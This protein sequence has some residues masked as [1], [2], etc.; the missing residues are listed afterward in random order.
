MKKLSI[1]LV[2]AL[3]LSLF[4]GCTAPEA[5]GTDSLRV[6]ITSSKTDTTA[7]GSDADTDSS[8]VSSGTHSGGSAS[9][10]IS[11]GTESDNGEPSFADERTELLDPSL[12]ET[13]RT[14]FIAQY[15]KSGNSYEP[16]S[17]FLRVCSVFEDA[18]V[19]FVDAPWQRV[20]NYMLTES[21]AEQHFVYPT[22]NA[23]KVYREGRFYSLEEAYQGNYLTEKQIISVCDAFYWNFEMPLRYNYGE[24]S[25]NQKNPEISMPDA[26]EFCVPQEGLSALRSEEQ[27]AKA[28]ALYA[29]FSQITPLTRGMLHRL[30]NVFYGNNI[31]VRLPHDY[32]G[33]YAG[34]TVL[35]H[36][37][38]KADAITELPIGEFTFRDEGRFEFVAYKEGEF[39]SLEQLYATG[40]VTA[41][42]LN[43]IYELHK[44]RY[45]VF[46]GADNSAYAVPEE[47][48]G[49]LKKHSAEIEEKYPNSGAV[50]DGSHVVGGTK[51]DILARGYIGQFEGWYVYALMELSELGN[52]IGYGGV[53]FYGCDFLAYKEGEGSHFLWK[54]YDDGKISRE[55]LVEIAVKYFAR[56]VGTNL[57]FP[58]PEPLDQQTVAAL[59]AD[60]KAQTG[61]ELSL[62][63]ID[64]YGTYNGVIC[65]YVYGDR[66]EDDYLSGVYG[67]KDGIFFPLNNRLSNPFGFWG[68]EFREV[69]RYHGANQYGLLFE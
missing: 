17:V 6:E 58:L 15:G 52:D 22:T 60:Y 64:Y 33:M 62:H 51:E 37:V 65:F 31:A 4:G 21:V 25:A 59:E 40:C 46:Y 42:D 29:L 7:T 26:S 3:L 19:L 35:L 57:R 36:R 56:N 24:H 55:S 8:T 47:L 63:P 34:Y 68:V 20:G 45:P 38:E 28:D 53:Y 66:R 9:E 23:L 43:L 30:K 12:A 10:E 44:T 67:Y 16:S 32:Y 13:M 11:D 61:R 49:L 27:L 1:L 69:L 18:V 50:S 2:F 5:E 14:D 54:I 39:V 41:E 48:I